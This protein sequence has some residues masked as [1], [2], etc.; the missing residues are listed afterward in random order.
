MKVETDLPIDGFV[1][2]NFRRNQYI[3][4]NVCLIAALRTA[5]MTL[6]TCVVSVAQLWCAYTVRD[7]FLFSALNF[8][9]MNL[10]TAS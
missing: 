6:C 8:C 9:Q 2:S 4:F 1:S 5:S 10:T 3:F 7:R